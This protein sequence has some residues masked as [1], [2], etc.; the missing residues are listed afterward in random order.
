MSE[1]LEQSIPSPEKEPKVLALYIDDD[2]IIIQMQR[3]FFDSDPTIVFVEC[4]SIEE[5]QTAIEKYK[6]L[7]LF[8]DNNL[9]GHDE[10]LKIA[11][12]LK[13]KGSAIKI[14]STTDNPDMTDQ[15]NE[16]GIEIIGK[17]NNRARMK[18]ILAELVKNHGVKE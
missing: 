5:A 16:L 18:S 11:K 10:G 7:V 9:S 6:P 2:K 15:Y 14:Y 12:E 13:E 1:P 3:R 8:L 4:H 17:I